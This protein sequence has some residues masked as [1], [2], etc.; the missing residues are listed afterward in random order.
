MFK[1]TYNFMKHSG[2]T[3]FYETAMLENTSAQRA[4]VIFRWGKIDLATGGRGETQIHEFSGPEAAKAQRLYHDKL[5]EKRKAKN[6]QSYQDFFLGQGLSRDVGNASKLFASSGDLIDAVMGHYRQDTIEQ[7]LDYLKVDD[8]DAGQYGQQNKVT[9]DYN[10]H[11][12][13]GEEW[14]SF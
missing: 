7:I 1:V 5:N 14:G 6:G 4:M 8:A 12:D 10:D 13:R 2:G 9:T 11:V 3:K